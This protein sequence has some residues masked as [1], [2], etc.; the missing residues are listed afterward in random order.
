MDGEK[1]RHHSNGGWGRKGFKGV[2]FVS[3]PTRH[4]LRES[5][6]DKAPT[7]WGGERSP[8]GT[9]YEGGLDGKKKLGAGGGE[10]SPDRLAWITGIM[11]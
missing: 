11:I 6:R 3:I 10:L 4:P 7:Q 9:A 1:D 2:N 5:K 8:R